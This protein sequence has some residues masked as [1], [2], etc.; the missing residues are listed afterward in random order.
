MPRI[1]YLF[2]H[3]DLYELTLFKTPLYKEK[4]NFLKKLSVFRVCNIQMRTN[5]VDRIFILY[6]SRHTI[7]NTSQIYDFVSNDE[8]IITQVRN[9]L[10]H[11]IKL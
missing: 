6:F 3:V 2:R 7:A 5:N 11:W 1:N 8:E 10:C 4:K 9:T